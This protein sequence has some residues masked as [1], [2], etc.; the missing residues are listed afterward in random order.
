MSIAAIKIMQKQLALNDTEYR[1]LLEKT[2]GVRSAKELDAEQQKKVLAAMY[3]LQRKRSSVKTKT[4]A[5]SKIWSL[6]YELKGYLTQEQQTIE[7]LTGIVRNVTSSS[8]NSRFPDFGKLDKKQTYKT[9]EA[10]K[11]RIEYE[12]QLLANTVPF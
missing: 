9:I 11:S 12:K 3:S 10:L 2:T 5:E 7:Y 8:I 1:D 6:W 4:P